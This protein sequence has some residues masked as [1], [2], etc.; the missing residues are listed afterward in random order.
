MLSAQAVAWF[1]AHGLPRPATQIDANSIP[2][3][4]R[5]IAKTELLSF[6]S[7]HTLNEHMHVLR[8]LPLKEGT[9]RRRLGV[10]YRRHGYLSPA[11]LRLMAL[12]QERGE[13]LFSAALGDE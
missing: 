13:A 11:A 2:L 7:R 8:E 1:A 12:L 4:P 6:L 3:L 10:S 9:L 5:L